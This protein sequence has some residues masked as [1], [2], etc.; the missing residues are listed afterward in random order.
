[1]SGKQVI[2]RRLV[3][4]YLG[5]FVV[6]LLIIGRIIYLQFF[7]G[8]ELRKKAEDLTMKYVSI[9]P[10]RGDIYSD[11][12]NRLLS[13][14]VPYYEI[15]M[16]LK[17]SG[18]QDRVFNAGIDSL[19]YCL[20]RMFRDQPKSEYK[21]KLTAARRSGEQILSHSKDGKSSAIAADEAVPDFQAWQI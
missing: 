9:E 15:R 12:G 1:M 6:A 7:V 21:R 10:N 3:G 14:S 13:T 19:S 5:A 11:D 8:D 2:V 17:S 20:S 18:M 16:D 4:I